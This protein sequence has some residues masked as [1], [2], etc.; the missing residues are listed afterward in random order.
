[1]IFKYLQLKLVNWPSNH[2]SCA[3]CSTSTTFL[4]DKRRRQLFSKSS[5]CCLQ[6]AWLKRMSNSQ[7]QHQ[8]FAHPSLHLRHSST[9]INELSLGVFEYMLV[10]MSYASN[11]QYKQ[12]S[13]QSDENVYDDETHHPSAKNFPFSLLLFLQ[14]FCLEK[15]AAS[16]RHLP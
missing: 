14:K 8:L 7:S 15:F 9:I 6:F 10:R 11:K 5:V 4:L 16:Q 3:C 1:M 13:C 12:E 2:L